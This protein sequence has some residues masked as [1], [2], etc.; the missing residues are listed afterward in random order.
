[1]VRVAGI[2][3]LQGDNEAGPTCRNTIAGGIGLQPKAWK[4]LN[5]TAMTHRPMSFNDQAS[6]LFRRQPRFAKARSI[7]LSVL[8]WLSA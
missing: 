6:R 3:V 7:F 5:S 1:M 8:Y 4:A 2:G